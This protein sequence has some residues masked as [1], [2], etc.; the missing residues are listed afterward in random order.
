MLLGW[1]KV[2]LH[3]AGMDFYLITQPI[4]LVKVKL[5]KIIIK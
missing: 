5:G 3:R 4:L 1:I 2:G